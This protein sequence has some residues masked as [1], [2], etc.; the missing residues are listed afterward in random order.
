MAGPSP[1]VS[2]K[3][4]TMSSRSNRARSIRPFYRLEKDGWI[5]R[6]RAATQTG[7]EAKFYSLTSSGRA[8]LQREVAA[9]E[10]L[11]GAIDLVGEEA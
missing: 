1:N 2:S 6:R 9:W 8:H 10:R 4:R 3:F 11:S 7:R 5:A